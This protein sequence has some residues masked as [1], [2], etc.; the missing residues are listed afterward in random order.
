MTRAKRQWCKPPPKTPSEALRF[1]Y[2]H[3]LARLRA[4]E[5]VNGVNTVKERAVIEKALAELS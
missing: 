2:E 1:Y 3:E 4:A 5:R